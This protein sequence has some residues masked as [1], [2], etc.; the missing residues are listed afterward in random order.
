MLVA[1]DETWDSYT[2]SHPDQHKFKSLKFPQ[3]D[4]IATLGD[5]ELP[6]GRV[7]VK[8]I[9]PRPVI[10]RTPREEST[11]S[12]TPPPQPHQQPVTI[13]PPI[14]GQTAT[15]I[16]PFSQRPTP[17]PSGPTFTSF[18]PSQPPQ[19]IIFSSNPAAPS[20]DDN[21]S[22]EEEEILQLNG[23]RNDTQASRRAPGRPRKRPR[24]ET[25]QE[26]P[27]SISM[28]PPPPRSPTRTLPPIDL[29]TTLADAIQSLKSTLDDYVELQRPQKIHPSQLP[30]HYP[31]TLHLPSRHRVNTA[32]MLLLDQEPN[33]SPDEKAHVVHIFGR[34]VDAADR[35]ILFCYKPQAAAVRAA[36]IMQLL[37]QIR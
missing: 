16:V 7:P 3:F 24:T 31:E 8:A 1:S 35:Y 30:P 18:I 17:G 25:P 13:P 28:G 4:F 5:D 12:H 26:I 33:L 15:F 32:I 36:W 10:V 22:E 2:K 21:R 23:A 14:H 19:Q 6:E 20:P 9:Q 29:S 27:P 34:D 11:P 37:S